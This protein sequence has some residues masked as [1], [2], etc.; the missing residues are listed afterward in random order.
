MVCSRSGSYR[1]SLLKYL[2]IA[3]TILGLIISPAF[4]GLVPT[5][6]SLLW[7][8][9]GNGLGQSSYL[10]GT[11]HIQ[12]KNKLVLSP[13]R[14]KYFDRTQQLYL[15]LDFDDPQL[16]TEMAKYTQMPPGQNLQKLLGPKKYRKAQKYFAKNLNL[17]LEYFS[18]TR[19][20]ILSALA[21]PTGMK[22]PTS[23]WEETLTK[24]AQQQN[25]VVMGLETVREQF[26]LFDRLT[27]K[28]EAAMLMTVI[29][30]PEQ[31]KKGFQSLLAAYDRQDLKQLQTIIA[32]DPSTGKFNKILLDQRN[33][34]WIPLIDRAAKEKP[35]FFGVGAGHLVGKQGVIALLR[36]AGFTLR[37]L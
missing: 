24:M 10:F 7:E 27:L 20:F 12:C 1:A 18:T 35:T 11:I 25:R 28:Q 26:A 32:A 29:D 9:S 4:S 36:K 22:C 21:I 5:E 30:Y 3:L 14:Q 33:Q 19:P 31:S 37:P 13:E 6:K 17:P 2:I 23:S 15:E 34:K 16:Q 8:I